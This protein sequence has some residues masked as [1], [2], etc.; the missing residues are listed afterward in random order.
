MPNIKLSHVKKTFPNGFEVVKDFNM[1][2]NDG[3]FVVFLGPSGSGKSTVLRMVAGLEEPSGGEIR[4]DGKRLEEIPPKE[5]SMAMLFQNY[6]VYPK[7]TVYENIGFG[8]RQ[9]GVAEEV[10][11]E[12][13]RLIANLLEVADLLKKKPR[14]L[15]ASQRQRVALAR[16]LIYDPEILV[17][18][19][20]FANMEENVRPRISKRVAEIHAQMKG[21]V[22]LVTHNLPIGL[23]LADRV[24]MMKL[25]E[26]HQIGTPS[27]VYDQPASLF[28]A[29]FI[30]DPKIN[31]IDG[32]CEI[33]DNVAYITTKMGEFRLPIKS[34]SVLDK[35]SYH[36][37]TVVIGFRPQQ[38]LVNETVL[39]EKRFLQYQAK[40]AAVY[41]QEAG[42][43]LRFD[44]DG[45]LV[46][47]LNT[48]GSLEAGASANF[49]VDNEKVHIFD[50]VTKKNI[51]AH[52][53]I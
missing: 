48:S 12:K 4:I 37:Q 25:G 42:Q 1:E 8:L 15:T 14:S 27:E 17:M 26:V 53:N 6:A 19:E 28:V 10:I 51:N 52:T 32:H 24:V 33:Y 21:I 16:A 45:Y 38:M 36:Q 20:P 41:D 5:R 35:G 29:D 2:I 23:R 9:R 22:M 39:D 34:G 3:E 47:A 40:V 31:L 43:V 30:G 7:L 46:D 44:L 49:I 50:K 18:D 13:V 11:D